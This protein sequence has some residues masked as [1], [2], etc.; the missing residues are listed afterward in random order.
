MKDL[1]SE[2][3][4]I[5]VQHHRNG[6]SGRS[7]TAITFT[8]VD[9]DRFYSGKLTAIIPDKDNY[10]KHDVE[11]FVIH[12][13]KPELCYRGDNFN[14]IMHEIIKS[15]DIKWRKQLKESCISGYD[16]HND[17]AITRFKD[18]EEVRFYYKTNFIKYLDE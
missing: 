13:E 16:P 1:S 4:N 5:V 18:M 3:T 9:E 8:F 15:H 17:P 6:I 11:C 2:I 14:D 12:I 10:S 7:F